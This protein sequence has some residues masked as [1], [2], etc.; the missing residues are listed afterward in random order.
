MEKREYWESL[1]G[2]EYDT[3][4]NY[5]LY[6]EDWFEQYTDGGHKI[7]KLIDS[8]RAE[9]IGNDC[10]FLDLGCGNGQFLLLLDSTKFTKIVGLDYSFYA[11]E[12]AKKLGEKQN[13]PIDWLQAVSLW[14]QRCAE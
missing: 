8:L 7:V 6:G 5:S 4:T 9:C 1:Y 13:S 2:K 3:F 14:Y 11:I 10:S 12:L